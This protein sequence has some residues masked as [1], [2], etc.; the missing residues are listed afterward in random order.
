MKKLKNIEILS[1]G[2]L[3]LDLNEYGTGINHI[4]FHEKDSYTAY[5]KRKKTVFKKTKSNYYLK[6]KKII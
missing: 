5:Y 6:F 2:S 3:S 1:N 4:K